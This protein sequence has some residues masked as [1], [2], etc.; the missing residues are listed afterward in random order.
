ME[1][2]NQQRKTQTFPRTIRLGPNRNYRLVYKKGKS[3]PSKSLVLIYLKGKQIKIGFSVSSKV[4]NAVTRNRIRRIMREEA[5]KMRLDWKGGR[6]IF[7]ARP[8]IVDQTHG[9]ISREISSVIKRA[10]LLKDGE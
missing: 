9:A 8:C 1:G 7:V 10:G 5:R 6:Y 2:N 3:Y 4:G